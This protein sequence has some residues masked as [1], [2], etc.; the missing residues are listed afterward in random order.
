[1]HPGGVLVASGAITDWVPV[2]RSASKDF[3]ITQLDLDGVEALG[4][5]KIDLLGINNKSKQRK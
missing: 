1:M 3:H 5:V 2:L 4:L